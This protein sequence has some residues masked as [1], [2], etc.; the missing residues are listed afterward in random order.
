M[1][2]LIGALV[3]GCC[4][5]Y[6]QTDF[7]HR[8]WGDLLVAAARAWVYGVAYL[9]IFSGISLVAGAPLAARAFSLVALIFSGLGHAIAASDWMREKASILSSAKWLFP[10]EYELGLWSANLTA[11]LLSVAALLFIG[12][13]VFSF[14]TSVFMRRDA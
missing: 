6:L 11:N 1:G 8:T 14:G 9:G 3:A 5:A 12:G 7:A 2:L 10:G 13:A 4:G